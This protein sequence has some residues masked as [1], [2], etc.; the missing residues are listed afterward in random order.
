[1][2]QIH[3]IASQLENFDIIHSQRLWAMYTTGIDFGVEE[4]ALKRTAFLKDKANFT[5]ITKFMSKELEPTDKRGVQI[6]HQKF[7]WHHVSGK[8]N[9]L[10]AEIEKLETSLSDLLNKHRVEIDGIAV[11]TTQISKILNENPDRELRKKAFLARA[12]VNKLLVDAGFLQ[13]IELRKEYAAACKAKD[14]ISLR[15]E[16]DEL[17]TTQ[18]DGWADELRKRKKDLR[19]K[20]QDLAQKILGVE[21]MMAWDYGYT[22]NLLCRDN[23]AKVDIGNFFEPIAKTFA[24]YGWDIGKLNLTY[25]VFPRKNKSEWGY[26]FTIHPGKDSRVLANVNDRFASFDVLLHETAHGVHFLSLNPEQRLL[27]MGVSGIVAEGFANFFGG[28]SYQKEFVTQVFGRDSQD[29]LKA[30]GDLSRF[31]DF[32]QFIAVTKTLFDHE[33]YRANLKTNEDIVAL[34]NEMGKDLIDQPGFD[35]ETPWANLIHHTVA[36]I[37]LHNYFLGDVMTANMKRSFKK[38]YGSNAEDSPKRFGRYWRDKVLSPS[39]RLPF[40]ALH[41][42][43]SGSK[44]K[45][46]PYL[47]QCLKVG[48]LKAPKPLLQETGKL[49]TLDL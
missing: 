8:A 22:K 11:D 21:D 17:D 44:L 25:D 7:K 40:P 45:L 33:L 1:M 24:A 47:D 34:R 20:E 14:F 2:K 48:S 26:N 16:S 29:K 10:F 36:P 19:K 18:F 12:Q 42:S 5:I 23:N 41:E 27:N 13:L 49:R 38:Q 30:F 39:G 3:K 28:L 32:M 46:G 15:L 35:G 31:K 4:A 6:L 37:Y 43:V 9:K